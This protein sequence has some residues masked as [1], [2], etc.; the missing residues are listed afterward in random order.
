MC[1][2]T[3]ASFSALEFMD[4]DG[5][6]LSIKYKLLRGLATGFCSS[7]KFTHCP[8]LWCHLQMKQASLGTEKNSDIIA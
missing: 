3:L 7:V 4:C 2:L 5:H 1:V 6:N 8:I